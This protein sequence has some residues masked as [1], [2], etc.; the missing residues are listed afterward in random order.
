MRPASVIQI[1]GASEHLVTSS[2]ER[3]PEIRP[4]RTVA[5]SAWRA[6]T[7]PSC[8]GEMAMLKEAHED[9]KTRAWAAYHES[10]AGG[11]TG[12]WVLLG[13]KE[14]LKAQWATAKGEYLV[15]LSFEHL[16]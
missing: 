9:L 1:C 11:C 16:S 2:H 4:P 5:G 14:D 13:M 6:C 8:R 15:L 7:T 10:R 3:T 12:E